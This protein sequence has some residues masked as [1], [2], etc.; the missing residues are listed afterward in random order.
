MI[1]IWYAKNSKSGATSVTIAP[2]AAVAGGWAVIWEFAEIDTVTPLDTTAV[3]NSQ[4]PTATPTGG[5]VTLVSAADAVVSIAVVANQVT[6]IA[7]GSPFVNDSLANANGWAHLIITAPG[8][9]NAQ[10]T[11][12]SPGS[13]TAS[14]VSFRAAPHQWRLE[15]L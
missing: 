5:A 4:A 9:Y 1:D 13:Y 6:G 14:T 10:W 12:N 2:S 3:L 7:P 15:C 11:Q 8:T